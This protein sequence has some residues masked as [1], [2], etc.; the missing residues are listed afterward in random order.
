MGNSAFQSTM[1]ISSQTRTRSDCQSLPVQG[2]LIPSPCPHP[3]NDRSPLA[4]AFPPGRSLGIPILPSCPKLCCC[5]GSSTHHH[6]FSLHLGSLS[7]FGSRQLGQSSHRG[8]KM[9]KSIKTSWKRG[10]HPSPS[11]GCDAEES[12]LCRGRAQWRGL[13]SS[14]LSKS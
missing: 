6:P 13:P 3:G 11:P 14:G 12:G 10:P 4:P 8:S 5:S 2:E 1:N 9:I 7:L